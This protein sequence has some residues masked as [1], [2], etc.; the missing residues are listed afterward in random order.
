MH[1]ANADANQAYSMWRGA[2]YTSF[3]FVYTYMLDDHHF[4]WCRTFNRLFCFLFKTFNANSPG[5]ANA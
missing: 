4:A 3:Y 2:S 5:N 1:V